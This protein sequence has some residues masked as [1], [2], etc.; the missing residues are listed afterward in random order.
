MNGEVFVAGENLTD[1][2]Y[3]V[4]HG[5]GIQQI[6]SPLLVHGGVRFRF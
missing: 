6:G 1:R 4:D 3:T 5:G 2:E